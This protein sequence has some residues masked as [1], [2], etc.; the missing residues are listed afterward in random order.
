MVK[1]PVM[2]TFKAELVNTAATNIAPETRKAS[3]KLSKTIKIDFLKIFQ[4]SNI[5]N[6]IIFI[7]HI[8]Q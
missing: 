8:W 6:P 3:F 7:F 1:S 2:N 4:D 5:F